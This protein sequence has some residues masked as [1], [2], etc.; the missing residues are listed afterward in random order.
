MNQT[1]KLFV[2]GLIIKLNGLKSNKI[3]RV[4]QCDIL[5]HCNTLRS[6]TILWT[7]FVEPRS[8]LAKY[9]HLRQLENQT[10]NIQNISFHKLTFNVILR[11]LSLP[12]NG[13]LNNCFC[14][15]VTLFFCLRLVKI[16]T[17]VLKMIFYQ[18]RIY[19][20]H[21]SFDVNILTFLMYG[22]VMNFR[23]FLL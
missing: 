11:R 6:Q 18:R 7:K 23:H 1:T 19:T 21:K 16:Y 12:K 20:I 8:Q 17:V 3:Q 14:Y 4:G 5:F 22:L 13:A 9:I 10:F 15:N 2:I